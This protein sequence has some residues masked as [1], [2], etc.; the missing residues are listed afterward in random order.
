MTNEAG[1][2]YNLVSFLGV[3]DLRTL[4]P[5]E[6][7]TVLLDTTLQDG[8]V[9]LKASDFNLQHTNTDST[10]IALDIKQ[11]IIKLAWHQLCTSVFAEICPGYSSKPHAAL[12][13][14]EQSYVDADGNMVS[15]PLFAYY[16]RMMNGMRPF[17]G[18]ARFPVSVCNMVIDGLD[19]RLVPIFRRNYKDYAQPYDLQASSQRSK[20]PV[21]LSAMQMSEDE[22][23]SITAIARS[24]VN[25]Q[26]FHSDALAFPS[27][28][29]TTLNR[30][31]L[32]GGGG[33]GYKSDG[34]GGYRTNESRKSL[35]KNDSCFDCKLPHPW[36]KNKVILCPNKDKPGVRE[37]AAKVY[38]AWL[39]NYNKKQEGCVKKRKVNYDTM[40]NA[41]KECVKEAVL[42][43][44]GIRP[45]PNANKSS[46]DS[47]RKPIIYVVDVLVLF[48]SSPSHTI[49]PAPIMSNFPHIRLQLRSTLDCAD[50][51]VLHCVVDT[52]A[53]LTTGN[54]HF[55][56]ALAKKYPHCIAKIYVPEDYNPIVLSGIVQCGGESVTT[57]LT[58]GFQ[59][60][61][62]YKTRDGQDTSILIATGPHITVITIVGLPFIQATRMIIDLSNN[63]TDMRALLTSPFPL[64]Y[65]CVTVH[66]PISDEDNTACIHLSTAHQNM[67]KEIEALERRFAAASHLADVNDD[68]SPK[69][70]SFGSRAVGEPMS[71]TGTLTPALRQDLVLGKHGLIHTPMDN[72]SDPE[73][74]RGPNTYDNQ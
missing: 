58:V 24:S 5:H 17:A 60:S 22:V 16:Q 14:I 57:E 54:F 66:V 71:K 28:A 53:A 68:N 2:A 55:V 7:Q 41:N 38:A 56:A 37:E 72:Y 51:P 69:G 48:L 42:A 6:V 18:E 30:Y 65:R 9:L 46:R 11:K 15:T 31:S 39:D 27:Q 26:A 45:N 13:H 67:I 36:M 25:G 64:E 44:M 47:P 21:I 59:F 62:P 61:L 1:G 23:K 12:D 70:V 3:D 10:D 19:L 20:F 63:V 8:P 29:E 49:M 73:S 35:G 52:A 50:C 32:G 33:G 74:L 40:S 34:S 43:S 4:T